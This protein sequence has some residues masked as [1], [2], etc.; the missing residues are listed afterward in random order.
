MIESRV[1]DWGNK[2]RRICADRGKHRDRLAEE[3]GC[4]SQIGFHRGDTIDWSS[5]PALTMLIE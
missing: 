5:I 3:V 2:P 4:S 1:I